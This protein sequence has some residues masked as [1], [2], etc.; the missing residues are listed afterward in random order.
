M[1]RK[2]I[3][4]SVTIEASLALTIF[5]L[6]YLCILS[7][8]YAVRTESAVQNGISRT[9]SE[10]SRYCY[11]AER[12]SLTEYVKKAGV[13]AGE[14]ID[15]LAGF[16]DV[17][18]GDAGESDSGSCLAELADALSGNVSLSGMLCDPLVRAV[19]SGCIAENRETADEYFL[20]LA[21]ITL[22]DIDFHY[23]SLLRDGKKIEIVAVYK[24]KLRTCGLFGKNGISL[25]MRN[26]AVSSAWMTGERE[27][28]GVIETS[29]WNLTSFER[30]KAFTE[31][32][33]SENIMDAVKGGKGIDLCRGGK[34]S[35]IYSLNVFASTYSGCS[36][37]GSTDPSD[38]S[39]RGQALQDKLEGYAKKLNECIETK[40]GS[41]QS[42]KNGVHIP[43]HRK[44]ARG[45]LVIVVPEE[46]HENAAISAAL[47]NA[48][49]GVLEN[50]GVSVRYE[51]RDR[52]FPGI[53][54]E[55]QQSER[56][57]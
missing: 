41:L 13:T 36:V 1:K 49:A 46:A 40:G 27:A 42:E 25:T 45:E 51:Y 21:G 55:N 17:K 20:N 48:A 35:M 38:Y 32:I 11:A 16:S 14:A 26:T 37:P 6:G 10:I 39:V 47:E 44:D 19:F 2:R 3:Y 4:G 7:L 56:K 52:A 23:S 5:I 34:Y 9:A 50:T 31:E 57:K 15:R 53:R 54:E 18:G 28:A 8:V 33:K 12:L 30:G 43:D 24:V 29:R 22:D